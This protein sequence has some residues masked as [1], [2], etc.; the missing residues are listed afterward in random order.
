M[1]NKIQQKTEIYYILLKLGIYMSI[2]NIFKELLC[3]FR[4]CSGY[5][6]L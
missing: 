4:P 1:L 6:G 5:A 2:F 3:H